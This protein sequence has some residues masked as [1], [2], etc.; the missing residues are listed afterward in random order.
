LKF[1]LETAEKE[2]NIPKLIDV[3]DILVPSP[4]ENSMLTYL[5]YFRSTQ[6]KEV[7]DI[8]IYLVLFYIYVC[9]YLFYRRKI[10]LHVADLESLQ[11][12]S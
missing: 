4:D 3:E 7:F 11:E 1:A 12:V 9:Y 8:L 2:M 6:L 5:S 10:M